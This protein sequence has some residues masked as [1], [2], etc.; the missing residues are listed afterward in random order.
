MSD[1]TAVKAYTFLIR[2]TRLG[3][4]PD[5]AFSRL[6]EALKE[7]PEAVIDGEVEYAVNDYFLVGEESADS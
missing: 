4:D 5:D 2:A 6:L 7:C 3:T 1:K